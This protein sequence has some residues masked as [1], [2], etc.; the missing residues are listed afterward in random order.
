MKSAFVRTVA[1]AVAGMWV[2]P[3][4]PIADCARTLR[5]ANNH[6]RSTQIHQYDENIQ[7]DV[8]DAMNLLL[9]W[10][11]PAENFCSSYNDTLHLL[12]LCKDVGSDTAATTA[13]ATAT[14]TSAATFG[15]NSLVRSRR[16]RYLLEEC[17]GLPHEEGNE[18][19]W[20]L[21]SH[22]LCALACVTV[23]ALAAGLTMGLLSL[24]PLLLLIRMRAGSTEEEK[25]QAATLLPIV[26]QHHLL[27]VT[28]LLLN[29]IANEALPL[30]LVRLSLQL[31]ASDLGSPKDDL[32]TLVFLTRMPGS[33]CITTGRRCS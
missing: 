33:S 26:K 8:A 19:F 6:I 25:K 17:G 18:D 13:T 15:W 28:L 24:D 32:T 31:E 27:L 10:G 12:P 30:F 4:L 3:H 11:V 5:N 2:L 14:T 1:V 29:S 23:A 22:A 21:I 20:F 7:N 9:S 16:Q